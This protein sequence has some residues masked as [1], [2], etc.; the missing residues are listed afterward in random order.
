MFYTRFYTSKDEKPTH[1]FCSKRPEN[2]ENVEDVCPASELL[3]EPIAPLT[4][5][6]VGERSW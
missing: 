3:L 5:N 6:S 4:R 1:F 2:V